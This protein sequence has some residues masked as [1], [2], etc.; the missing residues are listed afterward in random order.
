MADADQPQY[1]PPV[2]LI[3]G[4]GIA[5]LFLGVLLEQL[6]IPYHIFERAKEIKPLVLDLTLGAAMTIGATIL[7]VFEQLG[8]LEELYS[9]S[10]PLITADL[11]NA[12][13][14][15]IGGVDGSKHR[16]AVGYNNII[17]AR[18][19]LYEILLRRIPAQRI[20]LGKKILK[21]QEKEG[22]VMIFC[23]DNTS[24]EGNIIVGAD[25][26]YSG[27]RQSLYKHLNEQGLLPKSDQESLLVGYVSVVG[28]AKP[29][30]VEKYSQ[31][32]DDVSHFTRVLGTDN[33]SWGV[34]SVANKQV[35]WSL[36][37]QLTPAE[38]KVQHF[39]NSEWGPESNDST[40]KEFRS[41]PCPWGG[42]MGE[43][44]DDTPKELVSKVFLEEK[45]FKTWYHGRTV[46][47]GDAC[48]KMLPGAGVGAAT[49][50]QDAVVLANCLFSLPTSSAQ[51]ITF[52]FEEYYRQRYHRAAREMERSKTM[53]KLTTG[54]TWMERSVRYVLF[55]C[56]PTWLQHLI[57]TKNFEYRPQAAWL[58]L[59]E[60]RGTGRVLPQEVLRSV[61]NMPTEVV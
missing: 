36:N 44:V 7:P 35:C 32:K 28:V 38:A 1:N 47:I 27:V 14:A 31:L 21:T 50:M 46:L 49:A 39:R 5:G 33:R 16:E 42:T 8:L 34:F 2:V 56:I 18:P 48:H 54:Q 12:K 6:N 26:T 23:S 15:K 20:N 30:D 57:N 40:L 45:L 61:V 25:G 29:K 53:S 37:I 41:L 3:V 13:M 4:A 60:N 19:K 59:V 22:K 58:P 24:Y 9:V 55:N 11:Y 10:L 51:N 52:I 43:L 17:F